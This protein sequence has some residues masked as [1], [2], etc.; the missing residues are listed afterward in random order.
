MLTLQKYDNIYVNRLIYL[1]NIQRTIA[2]NST[3]I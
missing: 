3:M 2:P 1:Q